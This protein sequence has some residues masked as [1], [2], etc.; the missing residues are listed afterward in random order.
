MFQLRHPMLVIRDPDLIKQMVVKDFEHFSNHREF[1]F[2]DEVEPLMGKSLIMMRDQKWRDMRATLS[3]AFTG[4]KM[5]QMFRLI[6]ECAEEATSVLL[7]EAESKKSNGDGKYVPEM[8]D[9]FTRCMTD[10]IATT[11]FGL[12]VSIHQVIKLFLY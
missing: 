2:N 11:A 7:K 5:R 4:S 12:K 1:L 6:V 8:K 9:I 10:V 3:P